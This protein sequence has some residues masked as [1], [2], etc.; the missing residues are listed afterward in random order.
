MSTI[1]E[2]A[3]IRPP[4]PGVRRL[5]VAIFTL[6]RQLRINAFLPLAEQTEQTPEKQAADAAALTWLLD[7]D[8]PIQLIRAEVL[9]GP[10][11]I[12]TNIIP[13]YTETL[14]PVKLANAQREFTLTAQELAACEYNIE[15]KPS[16]TASGEKP[17]GK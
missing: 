13:A 4:F 15:P 2:N 10:E 9:R 11:H 3:F 6:A 1:L 14:H 5:S 8:N 7:A 17:S 12:L 16:D